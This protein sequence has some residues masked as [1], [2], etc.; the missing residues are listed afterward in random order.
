MT[1]TKLCII[2][3]TKSGFALKSNT[4]AQLS[5]VETLKVWEDLSGVCGLQCPYQCGGC[6][7]TFVL[8]FHGLLYLST[9]HFIGSL[10]KT[11]HFCVSGPQK[12][13]EPSV[14][15]DLSVRRATQWPTFQETAFLRVWLRPVLQARPDWSGGGGQPAGL[16]RGQRGQAH[17]EGHRG[18]DCGKEQT[19]LPAINMMKLLGWTETEMKHI[20]KWQ[21]NT[22][23]KKKAQI[24]G[25]KVCP[26]CSLE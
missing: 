20:N 23:F 14:Q 26:M 19:K 10:Y 22:D 3:Q 12:D 2:Q 16:Q 5:P 9:V 15:W 8:L 7:I 25:K 24:S 17:L 13:L 6:E 1:K 4:G 21:F 11:L 18:R